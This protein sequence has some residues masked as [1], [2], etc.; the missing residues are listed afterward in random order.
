V[1]AAFFAQ[2]V[3]LAWE[4]IFGSLKIK[5]GLQVKDNNC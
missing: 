4:I 3:E 2:V 1:F 5:N